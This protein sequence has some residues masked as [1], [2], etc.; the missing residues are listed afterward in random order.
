ME[1]T[2]SYFTF[3]VSNPLDEYIKPLNIPEITI[4]KPVKETNIIPF[5]TIAILASGIIYLYLQEK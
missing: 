5:V 1:T 4:T 2:N 3:N